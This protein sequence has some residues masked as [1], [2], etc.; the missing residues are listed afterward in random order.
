MEVSIQRSS[1][2]PW[3]RDLAVTFSFNEFAFAEWR[4]ERY[5]AR[6]LDASESPLTILCLLAEF[7]LHEQGKYKAVIEIM[8]LEPTTLILPPVTESNHGLL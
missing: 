8:E 2:A 3:L 6:G 5:G 7:S 4:Y 1:V